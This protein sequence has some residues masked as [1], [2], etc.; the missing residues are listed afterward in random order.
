MLLFVL[1]KLAHN[2]PAVTD[3]F[4]FAIRKLRSSFSQTKKCGGAKQH[5]GRSPTVVLRSPSRRKAAKRLQTCYV[6]LCR[7]LYSHYYLL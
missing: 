4:L 6:Q 5:K 7:T 1:A 2:V 3:V